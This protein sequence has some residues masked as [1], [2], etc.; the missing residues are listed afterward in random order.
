LLKTDIPD[1][2]K[3]KKA[4]WINPE[5]VGQDRQSDRSVLQIFRQAE[6]VSPHRFSKKN[7]ERAS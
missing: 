2:E 4:G 6:A 5:K 1:Y 3:R 7:R